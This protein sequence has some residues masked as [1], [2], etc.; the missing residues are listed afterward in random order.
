VTV[1]VTETA[2][3]LTVLAAE[4]PPGTVLATETDPRQP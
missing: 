2:P 4:P 3:P 1:L